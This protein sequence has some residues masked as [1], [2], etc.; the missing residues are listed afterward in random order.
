MILVIIR[1][2]VLSGKC[3]EKERWFRD[4]RQLEK[5]GK[6]VMWVIWQ[7]ASEPTSPSTRFQ[8]TP[9][10]TFNLFVCR[11]SHLSLINQQPNL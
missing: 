2:K 3:M 11:I 4:N 5:Y 6:S 7:V 1:M 8:F 10:L 9:D